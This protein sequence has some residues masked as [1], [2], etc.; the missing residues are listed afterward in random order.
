MS[1][2]DLEERLKQVRFTQ[3]MAMKKTH[4]IAVVI[5]EATATTAAEGT[6]TNLEEAVIHVAEATTAM[7]GV[8]ATTPAITTGTATATQEVRQRH[9]PRGRG[10]RGNDRDSTREGYLKRVTVKESNAEG[11]EIYR[12][13]RDYGEPVYDYQ[14]YYGNSY[15]NQGYYGDGIFK[16]QRLND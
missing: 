5:Q 13:D 9:P 12:E 7:A 8:E 10:Y 3:D 6:T 15:D 11:K 4:T 1:A 16:C 14:G 2:S